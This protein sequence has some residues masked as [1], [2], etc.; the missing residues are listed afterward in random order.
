MKLPQEW[1]DFLND[2][3]ATQTARDLSL[4][5]ATEY[6]QGGVA[7]KRELL[8]S[9]FDHCPPDKVKVV[10]LGQDP[11]INENQATG[12]AFSIN[13]SAKCKFPPSL[14]NIIAEV[15]N[16]FG[17]CS[18]ENG[19]LTPWADQG[20]LLLN[21]C[22]TTKLG[23][24]LAHVHLGW[25]TF[26]RAVISK[27]NDVGNIVFLLWGTQAKS[28]VTLLDDDKNLI[29]ASAHPSPLSASNGFFGNN[30][31]QLC[32]EFLETQGLTPIKW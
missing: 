2:Y 19:D 3:I 20:V 9:A 4:R 23:Q 22:L 8:F 25:D 17:T 26:T 12:M 5:V 11:Y 10:I 13:P 14:K 21:T 30:H 7:P 16:E 28:Y 15:K 31:F 32:N 18:V 6:A 24:S 1:N 29:L 27:L